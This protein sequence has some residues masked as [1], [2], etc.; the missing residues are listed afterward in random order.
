MKEEKNDN[1]RMFV[2][3]MCQELIISSLYT[4]SY[5]NKHREIR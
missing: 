5:L 3:S 1:K 4:L 2:N